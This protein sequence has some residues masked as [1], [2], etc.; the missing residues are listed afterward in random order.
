MD[1]RPLAVTPHAPQQ[2]GQEFALG[3]TLCGHIPTHPRAATTRLAVRARA[4]NAR[5]S[6]LEHLDLRD[7]GVWIFIYT[8]LALHLYLAP[9]LAEWTRVAAVLGAGGSVAPSGW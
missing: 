1:L 5:S 6:G 9:S 3:S 7:R 4:R 2:I 8:A